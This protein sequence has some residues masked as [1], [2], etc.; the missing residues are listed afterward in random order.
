MNSSSLNLVNSDRSVS[1]A[2]LSLLI[3][4]TVHWS[5]SPIMSA[6]KRTT[7][8]RHASPGTRSYPGSPSTTVVSTGIPSLDDILGGG[9]PLSCS[10][11]TAAPDAHSSYGELVQKY[12]VAQGLVKGHGV[13]LIHHDG[14]DFAKGCMWTSGTSSE[15]DEVDH[16]QSTIKIAWRYEEM[17]PFQTT[18]SPQFVALSR[19]S[20]CPPDDLLT[21]R[22]PR[23]SSSSQDFCSTLDLTSRV[24]QSLIDRTIATK[25]LRVLDAVHQT[26]TSIIQ[27]IEQALADSSSSTPFRICVPSF[28]SLEWGDVTSAVG[29]KTPSL[30]PFSSH[31][32]SVSGHR[33]ILSQV[34][35]A[36][37]ALPSRLCLR[38]SRSS[39]RI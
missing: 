5:R 8:T 3:T 11:L 28:G 20:V 16:G 1:P 25:Q 30:L 37:L 17:K 33:V 9:L 14:Q 19:L 4:I 10:L 32:P 6:F 23:S 26:A 21:F 12:Y 31:I 35:S 7:P 34:A 27:H 13:L 29:F 39:S 36:A 22:S 38:Q 15:D 24:P 18:V 2:S